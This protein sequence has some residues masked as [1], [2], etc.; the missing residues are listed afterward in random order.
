MRSAADENPERTG[1][2]L[3]AINPRWRGSFLRRLKVRLGFVTDIFFGQHSDVRPQKLPEP[4]IIRVHVENHESMCDVKKSKKG[5]PRSIRIS[6]NQTD[7]KYSRRLT[8][9]TRTARSKKRKQDRRSPPGRT[10][11][12][13]L[14]AVET[15]SGSSANLEED[16]ETEN[17]SCQSSS[18]PAS[19]LMS[20]FEERLRGGHM[21]EGCARR[22][23]GF[24]WTLL[25]S[26]A[27]DISMTPRIVRISE[28]NPNYKGVCHIA[29]PQ[30]GHCRLGDEVFGTDSRTCNAGA[31]GVFAVGVAN[32]DAGFILG[33]GRLLIKVW[34]P[35]PLS[36]RHCE[37]RYRQLCGL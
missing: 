8:S 22:E 26:T 32:T 28:Q 1:C 36:A 15:S 11:E 29:L 31:F 25:R 21:S 19:K 17:A 13:I 10:H 16:L 5:A 14:E 37:I 27:F 34:H 23:S 7:Q 33:T 9:R 3:S 12:Q 4:M 2:S 24:S 18:L 30:D 35:R 6:K 20:R